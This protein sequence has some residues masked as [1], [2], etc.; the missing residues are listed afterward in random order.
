MKR[1]KYPYKCT[2]QNLIKKL[3]RKSYISGLRLK[4]EF[5]FWI[6]LIYAVYSLNKTGYSM[7]NFTLILFVNTDTSPGFFV[8]HLFFDLKINKNNIPDYKFF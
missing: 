1:K 4:I 5:D 3:S 6:S 7:D 8:F 2:G